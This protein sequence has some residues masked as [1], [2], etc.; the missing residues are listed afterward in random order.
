ME[1]WNVGVWFTWYGGD[2]NEFYDLGQGVSSLVA[3]CEGGE[4]RKRDVEKKRSPW[5]KKNM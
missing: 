5:A 1:G 4:N 3:I 2:G